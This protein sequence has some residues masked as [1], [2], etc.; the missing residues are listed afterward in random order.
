MSDPSSRSSTYMRRLYPWMYGASPNLG[1]APG[2]VGATADRTRNRFIEGLNFYRD[3]GYPIADPGVRARYDA[4][5]GTVGGM[6]LPGNIPRLTSIGGYHGGGGLPGQVGGGGGNAVLGDKRTLPSM[7]AKAGSWINRSESRSGFPNIQSDSVRRLGTP[8]EETPIL[9]VSG[10]YKRETAP[11]PYAQ[12]DYGRELELLSTMPEGVLRQ[13]TA[14]GSRGVYGPEGM[15]AIR[16]LGI[17]PAKERLEAMPGKIMASIRAGEA[18]ER[19]AASRALGAQLGG[20]LAGQPGR[21]ATQIMETIVGPSLA[22][23]SRLAAGLTESQIEKLNTL[24]L[25]SASLEERNQMSK[26]TIGLPGMQSALNQIDAMVAR[27]YKDTS[28]E[29]KFGWSPERRA[30]LESQLQKQRA[31]WGIDAQAQA[32]YWNAYYQ[33]QLMRL[34]KELE[35]SGLGWDDLLDI[36]IDIGAMILTKQPA[37]VA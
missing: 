7:A 24:D 25:M 31:A 36:G 30:D 21:A 27:R 29:N 28:L 10:R 17:E 9:G 34:Q 37:P 13:Y 15:E 16:Q 8:P 12:G 22:R 20:K 23:E 18:Q 11:S 5:E 4:S 35:G 26:A 19:A 33:E 1:R 2:G 6:R 14:I 3:M 32:A